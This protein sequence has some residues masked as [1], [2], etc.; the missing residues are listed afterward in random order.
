MFSVILF[1]S[2]KTYNSKKDVTS[3]GETPEE[4]FRAFEKKLFDL[5]GE[6]DIWNTNSI[7]FNDE[8]HY[9]VV[10]D[11]FYT[12][13]HIRAF[14]IEVIPED[15]GLYDIE[16]VEPIGRERFNTIAKFSSSDL[17]ECMDK[18]VEAIWNE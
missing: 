7:I 14:Y 3:M 1:I 2:T 15:N 18:I 17:D 4:F 8:A 10:D 16:I 9:T 12:F 6:A 5:C 11:T 13:D